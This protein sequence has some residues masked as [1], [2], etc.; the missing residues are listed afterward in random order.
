M[1]GTRPQRAARAEY[2]SWCSFSNDLIILV[3]VSP[4]TIG[5]FTDISINNI[6]WNTLY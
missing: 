6:V 4:S 3:E 2:M 1:I 5:I